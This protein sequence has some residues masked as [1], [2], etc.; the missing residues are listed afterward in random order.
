MMHIVTKFLSWA[1]I[2][3]RVQEL[4]DLPFGTCKNKIEKKIQSSGSTQEVISF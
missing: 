2:V 4:E 3:D 1:L